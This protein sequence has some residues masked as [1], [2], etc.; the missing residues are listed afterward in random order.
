MLHDV[1]YVASYQTCTVRLVDRYE[2]LR[3]SF[4]FYIY[5]REKDFPVLGGVPVDF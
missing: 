1:S 3:R 4:V 5:P 2:T